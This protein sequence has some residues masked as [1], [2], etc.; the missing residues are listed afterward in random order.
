MS[1]SRDAECGMPADWV[2]IM[3]IVAFPNVAILMEG[4]MTGEEEY[5]W[6]D[7]TALTDPVTVEVQG[8]ISPR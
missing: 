8:V 6:A 2:G 5:P 7:L 4:K 3:V 1:F